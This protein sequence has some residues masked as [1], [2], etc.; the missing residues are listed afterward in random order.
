MD[1]IIIGF[2][3][4]IV[5]STVS[6]FLTVRLASEK[7]GPQRIIH[8]PRRAQAARAAVSRKRSKPRHVK[9]RSIRKLRMKPQPR[10]VET[11]FGTPTVAPMQMIVSS[12]PA[13]GLQAPEKL[14]TEHFMGS[15]SHQYG[16]V[17]PIAT[18]VVNNVEE[19][20]NV[21]EDSQ[22]SVR[23]L[24][25]MLVPPRAFG[26]RHANRT[27]SPVSRIVEPIRDSGHTSFRP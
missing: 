20:L 12:C 22:N 3:V 2:L 26:R 24:L 15:P 17:Q 6:V 18:A 25:Q 5:A 23:S 9:P 19:E 21:E 16:P 14:M 4:G 27:V 8:A 11:D 7:L 1:T 13:C 10:P